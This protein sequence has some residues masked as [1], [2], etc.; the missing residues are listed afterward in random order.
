MNPRSAHYG[1]NNTLQLYKAYIMYPQE[2]GRQDGDNSHGRLETRHGIARILSGFLSC[3]IPYLPVEC[4]DI[5]SDTRTF[6][7]TSNTT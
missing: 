5:V 7:N 2:S 4:I 3:H 1:I 6:V